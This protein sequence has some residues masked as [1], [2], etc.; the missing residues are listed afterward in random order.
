MCLD[1]FCLREVTQYGLVA[2][3]RPVILGVAGPDLTIV[4][5]VF[6]MS[7]RLHGMRPSL[8]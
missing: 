3:R 7:Y 2:R 5:S 8:T 6:A 1:R 4:R